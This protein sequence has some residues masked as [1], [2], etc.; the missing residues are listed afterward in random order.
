MFKKKHYRLLEEINDKKF[1]RLRLACGFEIDSPTGYQSSS[2]SSGVVTG[3]PQSDGSNNRSDAGQGVVGRLVA[4]DANSGKQV[5]QSTVCDA[6]QTRITEMS[7]DRLFRV[8]WSRSMPIAA[9]KSGHYQ[10][11]TVR[12]EGPG[13]G[14]LFRLGSEES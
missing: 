9:N 8:P 13:S 1:A 3:A 4:V 6:T 7:G 12:H 5:W 11:S 10:T 14:L 2:S